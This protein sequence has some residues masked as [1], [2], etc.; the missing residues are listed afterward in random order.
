MNLCSGLSGRTG[1]VVRFV[2]FI[3]CVHLF[4][5]LGEVDQFCE[6]FLWLSSKSGSCRVSQGMLTSG[7]TQEMLTVL[8]LDIYADDVVPLYHYK[9]V[10]KEMGKS[11]F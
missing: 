6:A 2:L 1:A 10:L 8:R 3:L 4:F 7:R 5:V 9:S 11:H